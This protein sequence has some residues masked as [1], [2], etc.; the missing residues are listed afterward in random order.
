[1]TPRP[2]LLFFDMLSADA[3]VH[4][5]RNI[6]ATERFFH[7]RAIQAAVTLARSNL[8]QAIND[9]HHIRPLVR[10]NAHLRRLERDERY[11]CAY[12]DGNCC[13]FDAEGRYQ[14][15]MIRAVNLN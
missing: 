4:A 2:G 7:R 13:E 9:P 3:R 11:L 8:H 1:M 10:R 15:L 6:L 14:T 5:M 12:I